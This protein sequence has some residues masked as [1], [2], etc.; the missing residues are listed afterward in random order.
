MGERSTFR[1]VVDWPFR[2][3]G[4][5]GLGIALASTNLSLG[6]GSLGDKVVDFFC[7]QYEDEKFPAGRCMLGYF[8]G[9]TAETGFLAY[10]VYEANKGNI[11]PLGIK[12]LL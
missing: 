1:K 9:L 6:N 8:V 11:L 4:L 10:S 5:N 12:V 7:P 3:T 2:A